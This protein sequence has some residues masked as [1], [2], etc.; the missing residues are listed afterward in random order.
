MFQEILEQLIDKT[1]ESANWR[2]VDTYVKSNFHVGVCADCES[3]V[4]DKRYTKYCLVC[5]KKRGEPADTIC[6]RCRVVDSHPSV[7]CKDCLDTQEIIRNQDPRNLAYCLTNNVIQKVSKAHYKLSTKSQIERSLREINLETNNDTKEFLM[8]EVKEM[9]HYMSQ[10]GPE[11]AEDFLESAMNELAELTRGLVSILNEKMAQEIRINQLTSQPLKSNK[12]TKLIEE[13]KR[14]KET[15]KQMTEKA[16]A[17]EQE[18]QRLLRASDDLIKQVETLE[19]M[20]L[21]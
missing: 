4:P 11:T 3:L 21:Y 6:K 7:F 15:I 8:E 5:L 2:L 20:Y 9:R 16:K 12:E 18:K 17:Q 10:L 14:L 1:N 19:R 13:N